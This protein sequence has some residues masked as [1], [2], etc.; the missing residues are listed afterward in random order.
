MKTFLF[1]FMLCVA[2]QIPAQEAKKKTTVRIKKV[3]NINGVVKTTDT[4]YTTD[5]PSTFVNGANS[6][7][8]TFT[9]GTHNKTVIIDENI[10]GTSE[11]GKNFSKMVFYSDSISGDG[12]FE[13]TTSNELSPEME[14]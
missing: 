11:A 13:M 14:K 8:F 7:A 4:T 10:T 6:E 3:E 1:F 9:N 5:D 12:P 2:L